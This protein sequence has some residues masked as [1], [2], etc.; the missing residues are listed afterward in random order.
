METLWVAGMR[1]RIKE[2]DITTQ[3]EKARELCRQLLS[4]IPT[5]NIALEYMKTLNKM[6]Q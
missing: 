2:C 6:P 3:R 1:Q 5:D 4:V